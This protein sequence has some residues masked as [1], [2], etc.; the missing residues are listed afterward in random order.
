[1]SS[2]AAE[3]TICEIPGDSTIEQRPKIESWRDLQVLSFTFSLTLS[4]F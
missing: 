1:M 4:I 3:C 2:T